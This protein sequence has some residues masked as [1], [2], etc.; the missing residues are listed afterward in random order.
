[1]TESMSLRDTVEPKSDQLNYDD[2][3]GNPITD[4]VAGLKQGTPEQPVIVRLKMHR[5]F[6]P[7]KSMRRV[8]IAAWGDK[9]KDWVGQSMTMYGDPTVKFGGVEVGGIRISH[10]TGIDKP[11]T[12]KL[13][14]TRSKR[15]DYTVQPMKAAKGGGE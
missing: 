6:K 10:V 3:A 7:C 11:L 8:L 15:A 14:T 1:M 12:L 5:D 9:G 4:E 2:V 13:T